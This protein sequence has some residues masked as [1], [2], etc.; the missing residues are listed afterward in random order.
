MTKKPAEE[1]SDEEAERRATEALR[2]ALTAPY[3]PQK[4][5]R[6]GARLKKNKNS[7]TK[8]RAK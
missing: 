2:R 5:M 3:K 8:P 4:A 7:V 6:V 1:V